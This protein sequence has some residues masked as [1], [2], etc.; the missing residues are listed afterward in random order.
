MFN[1]DTVANAK[2]SSPFPRLNIGYKGIQCLPAE[3]P[4]VGE[5]PKENR[6]AC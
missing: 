1:W 6:C 2:L 4:N 5:T 3:A